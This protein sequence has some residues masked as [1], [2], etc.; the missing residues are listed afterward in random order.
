MEFYKQ[1]AMS[2]VIPSFSTS[3]IS[4]SR[5]FSSS[6]HG[7]NA[8]LRRGT[9]AAAAAAE[10]AP[11]RNHMTTTTTTTTTMMIMIMSMV[12]T[13]AVSECVHTYVNKVFRRRRTVGRSVVN[14]NMY[15]FD[16]CR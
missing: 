3:R 1:D 4:E 9:A 14:R 10:A 5:S 8:L 7:A 6:L 12:V 13:M 2:S 15:V 16:R 11:H